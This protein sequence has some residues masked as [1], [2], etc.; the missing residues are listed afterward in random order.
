MNR[1]WFGKA[2]F[3]HP[4]PALPDVLTSLF[5]T[6]E[7]NYTPS[8]RPPASGE[9]LPQ[10]YARIAHALSY[11]IAHADAESGDEEIAVVICT[12]AAPLIAMGRVLTGSLPPNVD[13]HDFKTFTA[14]I[15]RFARRTITDSYEKRS[16]NL[17]KGEQVPVI[18]WT[19]GK[20][21]MGGWNC[22]V[23][24]DTAHQKGGGEREW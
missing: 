5:P 23:N 10:L 18:D 1:E 8:C 24:C 9:S 19:G 17:Q 20:G 13:E 6:I 16:R 3:T 7:T 15:P 11:V 4:V 12:H 14:G 22:V 21:V 2:W